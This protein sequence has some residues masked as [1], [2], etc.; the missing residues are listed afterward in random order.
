[1]RTDIGQALQ[2]LTAAAAPDPAGR[3]VE[4]LDIAV[5]ILIDDQHISGP[6]EG[7]VNAAIALR[8]RLMELPG[9][10]ISP[11]GDML[12]V[13]GRECLMVIAGRDANTELH[14]VSRGTV[15]PPEFLI[16]LVHG[17]FRSLA[18]LWKLAN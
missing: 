4:Q 10:P 5:A 11:D 1:G 13:D 7:G 14:Y 9:R 3:E 8:D 18:G 15:P 16:P 17:F 6:W 12:Y 2:Q